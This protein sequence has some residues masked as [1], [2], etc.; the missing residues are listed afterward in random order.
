MNRFHLLEHT[1]DI[2]IE[3]TAD[4]REGLVEQISLGLKL[5]LFG[6]VEAKPL[7]TEIITAEGNTLEETLVNWLNE[8]LF[9]MADKLFIP[10]E[11]SINHYSFNN[12]SAEISGEHFDPSRHQ[13][14]RD[15]KAV[16]HHQTYVGHDDS[17]WQSTVYL[18]L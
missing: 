10:A 11:I 13:I 3:A 15:I 1:A 12:I 9:L 6:A 17:S 4:S 16:T 18:D 2:G 5:L 14:L 8:L 7:F